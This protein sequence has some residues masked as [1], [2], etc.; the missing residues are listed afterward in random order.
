MGQ[1]RD[2]ACRPRS[3]S[4]EIKG[5]PIPQQFDPKLL[6]GPQRI[7][8]GPTFGNGVM[9]DARHLLQNDKGPYRIAIGPLAMCKQQM[10][11]GRL[12][13]LRL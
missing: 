5:Q 3:K 4:A 8:V 1:C 9:A 11:L 7:G 2:G 12:G 6:T 10:Q 13:A